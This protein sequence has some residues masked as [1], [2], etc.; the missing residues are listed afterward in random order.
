M[1]VTFGTFSNSILPE[2]AR[3]LV[4]GHCLYDDG[5][6]IHLSAA[7]VMPTHVHLLFWALRD[8]SGWPFPMVDILQALKSSSAHTLNK[9]LHRTG[10]VWDE[11]SFDHVLRSD[12]SWR[13]KREYIRQNPVKA[14]L[15][16]RPE[17][18]RWLWLD[19]PGE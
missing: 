13:Q 4:L 17:D 10:P 18:Y 14:G 8:Q 12:E 2:A 6:R 15:V 11:E 3:D 9:L 7:V 1:F 16:S 19:P 5:K